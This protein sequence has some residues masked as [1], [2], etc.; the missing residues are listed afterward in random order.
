MRKPKGR[1]LVRLDERFLHELLGLPDDVRVL[2]SAFDPMGLHVVVHL[3]S[4]R[5][6]ME[7]QGARLPEISPTAT[8][9]RRLNDSLEWETHTHVE[10]PL[11]SGD[12]ITADTVTTEKN[13]IPG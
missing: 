12:T 11:P 2:G 3:E 4:D 1:V 7:E 13:V 9:E 10:W 8:C 6:P 5:F